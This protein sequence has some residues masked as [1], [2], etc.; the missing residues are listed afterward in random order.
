MKPAGATNMT[1]TEKN[2]IIS[3]RLLSY[4]NSGATIEQAF[5]YVFGPGWYE[6]LIDELYT[7]LR[8]KAAA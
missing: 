1:T 8:A 3:A 5:G 2:A 6:C 7:E 4:I